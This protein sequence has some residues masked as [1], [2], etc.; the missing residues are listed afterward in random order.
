M[1]AAAAVAAVFAATWPDSP[2]TSFSADVSFLQGGIEDKGSIQWDAVGKR[3]MTYHSNSQ[4]TTISI[5]EDGFTNVYV[6]TIVPT[7][8]SPT[9]TCQKHNAMEVGSPWYVY[10]GGESNSSGCSGGSLFTNHMKGYPGGGEYS[11]CL[12]G[13]TPVYADTG[14]VKMTYSNFKEGRPAV[15]VS[16]L[17]PFL[18]NCAANCNGALSRPRSLVELMATPRRPTAPQVQQA[19][20]KISAPRVGDYPQSPPPSFSADVTF[21]QAGITSKGKY[22]WDS[23][24]RRAY[25]LHEDS[26]QTKIVIQEDGYVETYTY[27][28]IPTKPSPTCTCKRL[29][30]QEVGNPWY[31]YASAAANSSGCS[32]GSLYSNP[33]LGFPG[34]RST[35]SIC[36]SGS[37][38]VYTEVGSVRITYDSFTAGRPADWNI[39]ALEQFLPDCTKDCNSR[40]ET[41]VAAFFH[42]VPAKAA[43]PAK[44]AAPAPKAPQGT[45]QWPPML[46]S[47]FSADVTWTVAGLDE[48]GSMAWDSE[49]HRAYYYHEDSL[50]TKI[51]LQGADGDLNTYVYNIVATKPTPTCTCQT[52]PDT[53]VTDPWYI[54]YGGSLNSTGCSGGTLYTNPMKGYS[55]NNV[56]PSPQSICLSGTT[57]K[58]TDSGVTKVTFNSFTAGRPQK[59]NTS[60]LEPFLPNCAMNCNQARRPVSLFSEVF[61]SVPKRH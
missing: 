60:A 9:C 56:L 41:S 27:N 52:L 42:D 48:K 10:L 14:V 15:N 23:V 26:Q 24:A 55:G 2:P 49:A 57:P 38:P 17:E 59:W 37:K 4:Q 16:A 33:M 40:L 43:A 32:G 12:N 19:P 45:S 20:P 53:E 25:Q 5:Q 18:P 51:V 22:N 30:S 44:P 3:A 35:E 6:Y 36:L 7:K 11:L 61:H 54:Y 31:I 13:K 47:S 28:V 58:Y 29:L 46:Q 1:L 39:S 21:T 50:Q 34:Q 8:P